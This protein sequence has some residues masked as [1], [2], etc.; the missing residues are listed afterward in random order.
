M[1]INVLKYNDI[2]PS[3]RNQGHLVIASS[4]KFSLT[5]IVNLGYLSLL[6]F[7][8]DPLQYFTTIRIGVI[9]SIYLGRLLTIILIVSCLASKAKNRALL[10]H[11]IRTVFVCRPY[12]FFVWIS[13]VAAIPPLFYLS[14]MD[15]LFRFSVIEPLTNIAYLSFFAVFP[16][17]ASS[18]AQRLRF[19]NLIL[20]FIAIL[21]FVGYIDF[22]SSALDFNLLGRSLFDRVFVG[23]RFHSLFHEPRDYAVSSI[24]LFS[25]L[26]A[27]NLS[28]HSSMRLSGHLFSKSS[29]VL[30]FLFLSAFLAN[31]A[32][33]AFGLLIFLISAL[34]FV[35]LTQFFS[36]PRLPRLNLYLMLIFLFVAL[37]S[38]FIPTETLLGERIFAIYD[39]LAK[40]LT[41]FD[42]KSVISSILQSPLLIPQ[43]S[44]FL[45]IVYFFN[46]IS[47]ESIYPTLFG[48]G[49]GFVST[50]ISANITYDGSDIYNSYAGLPRLLCETGLLG[51]TSFIYM[52]FDV[53]LRPFRRASSSVLL[54][55]SKSK[56]YFYLISTSLLFCV[57]L[58]HRRQELFLCMG[59][60][61]CY[62]GPAS[63]PGTGFTLNKPVDITPSPFG[64]RPSV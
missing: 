59:F 26:F 62:L 20:P 35:F 40:S 61:N 29:L 44:T 19:S 12:C 57:Y 58:T 64:S 6:Q 2:Q 48:Y 24:Y 3:L 22:L 50:L 27:A 45:P 7:L 23:A 37:I 14:R 32:S 60:I 38:V 28:S 33:F 49:H 21:L 1:L 47:F 56:K 5:L 13:L 16:S 41:S 11:S 15:L 63:S 10:L 36:F 39:S 25:I 4:P 43:A 17:L 53:T 51:L 34:C 9:P 52:F 55:D 42:T 31:S 8:L 46:S 30:F 54:S 18:H